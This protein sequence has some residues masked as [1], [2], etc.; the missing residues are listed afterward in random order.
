MLTSILLLAALSSGPTKTLGCPVAS[1]LAVREAVLKVSYT[2]PPGQIHIRR[3]RGQST[4]STEA[5]VMT[6]SLRDPGLTS[7]SVNRTSYAFIPDKGAMATLVVRR[8]KVTCIE[9]QGDVG[10]RP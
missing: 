1:R 2:Y 10:D 3:D 6:C 5:G 4:C 8:G 7:V 9:T